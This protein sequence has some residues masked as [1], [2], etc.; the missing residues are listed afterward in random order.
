[1]NR[2]NRKDGFTLAELLIVVAII[3]V[4]VA[5]SIPIFT[6]R[7]EKARES[8]DLANL[9]AAYAAGVADYLGN[10][11]TTAPPDQYYNVQTGMLES[12]TSSALKGTGANGGTADTAIGEGFI[13]DADTDY[14]NQAIKVTIT[15]D[16]EVTLAAVNP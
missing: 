13:Y 10:N 2:L 3:A 1:M 9:R 4:L 7:L 8:T 16:G 5:V 11:Y 14:A 12:N 15:A 6:S